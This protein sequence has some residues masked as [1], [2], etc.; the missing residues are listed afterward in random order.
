M[1]STDIPHVIVRAHCSDAA[2]YVVFLGN[3]N[4]FVLRRFHKVALKGQELHIRLAIMWGLM[5]RT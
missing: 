4:L 2:G 5:S 3:A 1:Q